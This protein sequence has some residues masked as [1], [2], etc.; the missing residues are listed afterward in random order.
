M[1]KKERAIKANNLTNKNIINKPAKI[2]MILINIIK[3]KFRIYVVL[4][5]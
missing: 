1:S 4:P 5:L 2:K 3:S